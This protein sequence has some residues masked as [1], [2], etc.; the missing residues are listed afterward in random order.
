M[1][2]AETADGGIAGHGPT[3]AKAM[4][5]QGRLGAHPA[6]RHSRLRSRHAAADDDD[7]ERVRLESM[8]DFYPGVVDP[9]AEV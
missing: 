2:L 6:Q 4:G 3:V 5:H 1:T 7:V 9:K 8:P